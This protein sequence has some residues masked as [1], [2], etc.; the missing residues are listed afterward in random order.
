MTIGTEGTPVLGSQGEYIT[1]LTATVTG[2]DGRGNDVLTYL[3]SQV[4]PC[5]FVP[6]AET[7]QMEGGR[8]ATSTDQL[9][10]PQGTPVSPLDQIQRTTGEVYHV[11]GESNTWASPWTG[12]RG[13]VLVKLRRVT[14]ATAMLPVESTDLSTGTSQS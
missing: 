7:E 3:P 11:V 12:T 4:G 9:Y 8:Q 2:T 13:P 14:G 10:L 1:Y 5:A 6:G